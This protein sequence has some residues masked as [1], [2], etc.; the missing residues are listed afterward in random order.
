MWAA[1]GQADDLVTGGDPAAI[2]DIGPV[3]DTDAEPGQVIFPCI[4][5]A[6]HFRSFAAKQGAAGLLAAFCDALY[7]G[8]GLFK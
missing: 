4:L 8:F 3:D 2:Y 7:H 5:H 1:G 6:R